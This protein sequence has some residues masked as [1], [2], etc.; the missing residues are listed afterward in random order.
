MSLASSWL[1]GVCN[2]FTVLPPSVP[3][4]YTQPR[5]RVRA[6]V[7]APCSRGSLNGLSNVPRWQ[8]PR[9][10]VKWSTVLPSRGRAP[11]SLVL[12]PLPPLTARP[13]LHFRP[14][15]LPPC[16]PGPKRQQRPRWKASSIGSMSGRP[17][18]RR[19]QAGKGSPG[20]RWEGKSPLQRWPAGVVLAGDGSGA[21]GSS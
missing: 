3:G 12:F 21:C 5:V 16:Q 19:P 9:T 10:Q 20:G 6:Y 17:T 2:G 14:R 15:V 11:R 4:F 13:S 8:K 1:C 18:I 7:V